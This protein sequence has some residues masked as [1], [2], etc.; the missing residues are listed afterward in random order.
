[1]SANIIDARTGDVFGAEHGAMRYAIHEMPSGLRLGITG[2]APPDTP[3]VLVLGP[4]EDGGYYLIGSARP[5]PQ[6][7]EN[8]RWGTPEVLERTCE[9]A[10]ALGIAVERIAPWYDVDS[11]GDLSRVWRSVTAAGDARHTRCWLA[12]AP[13]E[14]RVRVHGARMTA[15]E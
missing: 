2:F 15:K 6:I 4:A 10:E 13:S 8:I 1:V 5:L 14:V 9:A 3:E 12:A 7:F 11:P